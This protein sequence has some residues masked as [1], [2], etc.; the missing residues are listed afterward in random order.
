M[1]ATRWESCRDLF[2]GATR[3]AMIPILN[4]MSVA[5]IVSIPGMM[6]GQILSGVSPL[7]AVRYQIVVMCMIYGASGIATAIFITLSKDV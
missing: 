1:G 3:T 5:G 2:A 4:T 7:I 6:T